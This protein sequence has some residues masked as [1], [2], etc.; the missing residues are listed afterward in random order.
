MNIIHEKEQNICYAVKMK[1]VISIYMP[2]DI[3]RQ[4]C[5]LLTA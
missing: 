4:D 1:M 5:H 3:L 2:V